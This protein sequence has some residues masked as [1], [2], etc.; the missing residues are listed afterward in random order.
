MLERVYT[1]EC[2]VDS[3]QFRVILC[4]H[5]NQN[6]GKV[7]EQLTDCDVVAVELVATK[8]EEVATCESALNLILAG[9]ASLEDS[10]DLLGLTFAGNLAQKMAGSNKKMHIVDARFEDREVFDYSHWAS[11]GRLKCRPDHTHEA[12]E[13]VGRKIDIL[14]RYIGVSSIVRELLVIDQLN[15]LA[16]VYKNLKI[17]VVVGCAHT[18]I[19]RMIAENYLTER[20]FVTPSLDSN[21]RMILFPPEVSL[22]RAYTFDALER[23]KG[24]LRMFALAQHLARAANT[25]WG[26]SLWYD[27]AAAKQLIGNYT[28][29]LP[30]DN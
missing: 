25:V 12:V 26:P 21:A 20:V 19:P 30:A 16:R 10:D 11:I 22:A 9:E 14:Q 24:Q 29:E 13:E 4:E 1:P 7:A 17:G 27:E 18:A 28:A 15:E 6:A 8:S 2:S 23:G 5:Y 3:T